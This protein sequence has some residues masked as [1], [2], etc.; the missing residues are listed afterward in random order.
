MNG[1]PPV[2]NEGIVDIF[3]LSKNESLAPVIR[4]HMEQNGYQVT[5]FD[6]DGHLLE[7]LK[8]GKPNLII[9]DTTDH[10]L[11]F[12]EV[13]RQIKDDRDLWIIPVLILTRA[14]DLSDLL[15]VLDSNADNFISFPY[16]LPY[17]HSLI[18]GMLETRVERP[19]PEQIKT[20]FKIEH[21]DHD[22]V[23]T[24]DR[25]KLLEFLLSSFEIAVSRRDEIARAK[26]QIR[27]LDQSVKKLESDAG[28]NKRVIRAQNEKLEQKD[29]DL[30][31]FRAE[32]KEKEHL[33]GGKA[34]ENESL[35]SE[36]EKISSLLSDARDNLRT[37]TE[38]TEADAASFKAEIN[39]L[40]GKIT[41]LLGELDTRTRENSESKESLRQALEKYS[42]AEKS[43]AEIRIQKEQADAALANLTHEHTGVQESLRQ[44]FERCSLSEKNLTE[45]RIQKEQADTALA[46]LTRE[47]TGV[48][49]SLRQVSDRCS[50]AEKDLAEL[51]T[52]KAQ[53]DTALADLT[54][55]YDDVNVA[56]R[57]ER[58][59]SLAAEKEATTIIASKTDRENELTRILEELESVSKQQKSDIA[60][61]ADALADEKAR[62]ANLE[63]QI[64]SLE[65]EKDL[66]ESEL[67]TRLDELQE[68]LADLR[69]QY[70]AATAVIEEKETALKSLDLNFAAL[71]LEMD[72]IRENVHRLTTEL[73]D[74][75]SAL[76]D[77]KLDRSTREDEILKLTAEKDR[78]SDHARS[79]S[80]TIEEI[81]SLLIREKEERR[82]SEDRLN[83]VIGKQ[84][85]MLQNLR[86]AHEDVKSNLDLHRSDL[87]Q[88]R[89][90]LDQ[91]VRV[92]SE[93]EKDLATARARI[94]VL[95][96]ENQSVSAGHARNGQQ[97]RSLGDELEQIRSALETERRLRHVA[98]ESLKSALVAHERS[99]QDLGR[100]ISERGSLDT[101]LDAE[102]RSRQETERSKEAI[103]KDLEVTREKLGAAQ[104]QQEIQSDK[105]KAQIRDLFNEIESARSRQK[106][107]EDLVETLQR[108]KQVAENTAS[109]LSAEID[110]ARTALADEWED[111]MT[112]QE[113]LQVADDEKERV[114]KRAIIVKGPDLPMVVR[115]PSPPMNIPPAPEPDASVITRVEDL[116]EDDEPDGAV[117]KDDPLAVENREP[118]ENTPDESPGDPVTTV[119]DSYGGDDDSSGQDDPETETDSPEE[120]DEQDEMIPDSSRE[121]RIPSGFTFNRAQWFDLLRWSHHSGAL[122]QE[123]RMQIVRMGRL[124][125]RGR[126]LTA[127]QEEQVMEMIALARTLG[128][129]F[130]Q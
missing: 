92:R 89:S 29:Q 80:K 36:T 64:T 85:A 38:E 102:H 11:P 73:E 44:V 76:N 59:K 31:A 20:Q 35:K 40:N 41:D 2:G 4:E 57:A 54:R 96:E 113:R 32:I 26:D 120:T 8:T 124:I 122:S 61:Y 112:D 123:Q 37:L 130:S 119:P 104:R 94:Q 81:Q 48:R 101:A 67:R 109:S 66:G 129:S 33:I 121:H 56:Y 17:L 22:F 111:H 10:A 14:A 108:E 87:V 114:T 103:Q 95:E 79:L 74:T 27:A 83:D 86:G 93:L 9:C 116:F 90:D 126:K 68:Q 107:L 84:D 16:D 118:A 12:Y 75:R 3:V 55:D 125:Q 5:L 52:E 7:A 46:N 71:N 106:T 43:L 78:L 1:P 127:K 6:D 24:A 34:R 21:N 58:E 15:F 105:Q 72:K 47:H 117:Q 70:S 100:L 128:Y 115:P 60:G 30:D 18:G 25:R 91:A 51:H 88:M 99:S 53:T 97:V 49:E 45:L 77:E 19:T 42:L 39:T 13:C 28:E 50:L 23:I 98:E 82:L 65:K 69:I 62:S 63:V 110:Q